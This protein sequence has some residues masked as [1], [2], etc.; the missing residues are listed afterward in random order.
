MSLQVSIRSALRK[1]EVSAGLPR[2]YLRRIDGVVVLAYHGVAPADQITDPWVQSLHIAPEELKRQLEFIQQH[3][4]VIAVN[5][6]DRSIRGSSSRPSAVLTFDDGYRNFNEQALP[7]LESMSMPATLFITAN[8]IEK[9]KRHPAYICRATIA[10]LEPGGYD[11][12]AIGERLVISGTDRATAGN[13][14]VEK[15]KTLPW[16]SAELL[17]D[18]LQGI[19]T[20]SQLEEIDARYATDAPMS[21]ADVAEARR[22]G[23]TIGSHTLDHVVLGIQQPVPVIRAQVIDSRKLIIERTGEC[24]YFAYPNGGRSD[25]CAAAVEAVEEAEYELAFTMVPGV[26]RT[27]LDRPQRFALPRLGVSASWDGFRKYVSTAWRHNTRYSEF[28]LSLR[29]AEVMAG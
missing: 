13:V 2:I 5:D 3:F 28:A 26:V 16:G 18:E 19:F 1:I 22:R 21:W 9:Q 10:S 29:G 24:K 12:D 17:L 8:N 20:P 11:L 23:V 27:G 4:R 25:I 7:V 6:I 14:I 15:V